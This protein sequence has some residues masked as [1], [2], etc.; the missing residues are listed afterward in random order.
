[1][2][3]VNSHSFELKYADISD[4]YIKPYT[5]KDLLSED[6]CKQIIKYCQDKLINSET[7]GGK[8]INVRN[9]QQC[10]INK[11]H[12]CVKSLFKKISN[13]FNMPVSNAESLQ[14]VRYKQNQFY[15]EHHDSCCDD[16]YFCK[17]FVRNGGQRIITVLMYLNS[18][19]E[20]GHTFFKNINLKL[21]PST[22]DAI[23][24]YPLAKNSKK[25]H[26]LALHEGLPITKGEK[27]I[28]NLWFRER[29]VH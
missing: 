12:E 17:E 25:C 24:F 5:V 14:V 20:G 27:W 19:F 13:K 18:E 16:N 7:I 4:P 9:S 11:D 6:E 28:A 23:V 26:P 1:V 3:V 15:K 21:K 29:T 2:W 10:W 22:G 8:N